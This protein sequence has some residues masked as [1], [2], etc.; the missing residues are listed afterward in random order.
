MKLM[1]MLALTVSSAALFST[2]AAQ[3]AYPDGSRPITVVVPFGPGS[4]TDIITRIISEEMAKDLGAPVV[5]MNR[6]GASGQVGTEYVAGTAPDGYTFLVGTNSTHS[7]NPFLFKTLRYDPKKD[8]EPVGRLTINPLAFL[9]KGDSQVSNPADF[10]E[11][12]KSN[13][14]KLVYGYGNTGGQVSAGMLVHMANLDTLAVPYKTTPQLFTDIINGQVDF[15]F[16][17]F[18]ASRPFLSSGRLKALATTSRE[19]LPIEPNLPTMSETPGLEDFGLFAW[20]GL[21]AP[22]GTPDHVIERMNK[23]LNVALNNPKVKSR[24][25][26]D[27]SSIVISTTIPEFQ[28]FVDQQTELW[29]ETVKNAGIEPQ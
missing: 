10:I 5:V 3:Q 9:V 25:Q 14:K 8:F 23:A 13:P 6:A 7:G 15:G 28:A 27:T 22:A 17:D 11:Y 2:A 18:A 1:K 29:R 21:F 19:R 12:A 20:L 4:G 24:L 26:N 16:V